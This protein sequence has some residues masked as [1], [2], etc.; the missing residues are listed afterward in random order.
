MQPT[1]EILSQG[2]EVIEGAVVDT[3][4]AWLAQKLV[5]M[6]Y[7]V[8]RHTTIGDDLNALITALRE[9]SHRSDLCISTGGLGPTVDDLTAEAVSKA[10]DR[11]LRLDEVALSQIE[12]W[13]QRSGRSMPAIN[14]RQA[15]LPEGAERIDNQWGTAPG[16]SLQTERC[17]FICLPGVPREMKGMFEHG[18]KESLESLYPSRRDH[19]LTFHTIGCGES[20]LQEILAPLS[21]PSGAKLGFRAKGTE[22]EVKVLLPGETPLET[23]EALRAE[24]SSLIGTAVFDVSL[25]GN[26]GRGLAHFVGS[27][28][29]RDQRKIV[30]HESLSR[31]ALSGVLSQYNALS[32]AEIHPEEKIPLSIEDET[33]IAHELQGQAEHLFRKG[34]F[35]AALIQRWYPLQ[36]NDSSFQQSVML[37]TLAATERSSQ[38]THRRINGNSERLQ[39]AATI[40]GLDGLRLLFYP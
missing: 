38:I 11:P 31:G 4:A 30:V 13:F 20:A 37:W 24:V 12:T 17:R 18:L 28:L 26:G 35:D 34:S 6:G 40:W 16:F 27:R 22:N 1:V 3:N 32:H 14:R 15:L 23:L 39:E 21:L 7:R 9:I 8:V 19:L 33:V 10:L 2:D 25:N 29:Q 36:G 5:D